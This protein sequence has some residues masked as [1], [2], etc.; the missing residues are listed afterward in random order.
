VD[1]PRALVDRCSRL[2]GPVAGVCPSDSERT[3]ALTR[4]IGGNSSNSDTQWSQ[5][6]LFLP[7][8]NQIT[9]ITADITVHAASGVS[10]PLNPQLASSQ[11]RVGGTFFNSGSGD[12]ADD[13]TA[14]VIANYFSGSVHYSLWWNW[15]NQWQLVN[16][17]TLPVGERVTATLRWDQP[18]HRFVAIVRPAAAVH[19]QQTSSYSAPDGSP[20]A[21]PSKGF[22]AA[23]LAPNCTTQMTTSNVE[24]YVDNVIINQ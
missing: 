15:Q 11:T 22:S 17:A 20:A 24:S 14:Y 6:D 13:L 16:I 12:P 9:S 1:R 8:A 5:S 7:N 18:N 23:A 2:L 3:P 19:Y 10:C 4:N 21:N